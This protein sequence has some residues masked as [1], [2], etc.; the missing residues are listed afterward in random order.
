M[1]VK[2]VIVA[3]GYGSR[4]LPVTRCVPKEM[5][6]ILDRP[7]IDYVLQEFIEAG[8]E[9][10]LV[11]SSRRKGALEDWFDRDPELEAVF[12]AEGRD[13]KLALIAPPKIRATVIRQTEMKGTG[14]ALML[15][16]NFAGTDPIVVAYPDD[17]FGSPNVSA[18]LVEMWKATGCSVMCAA[19]L[20]ERVLSRYGVLEV[21]EGRDRL[22]H[23]RTIVEKPAH[24]TA[25]SNLVSFGRFLFTPELFRHLEEGWATH[26]GGEYYHVHA[27][28]RLGAAGKL[29]A[30]ITTA[31]RYDT[32]TTQAWLETQ[33]DLALDDPGLG[34]AL[35]A[36]L[37]DRLG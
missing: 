8:I 18:Q 12:G 21:E 25:P 33:I 36:F 35:R 20:E 34:P 30:A 17:L 24:G 15:A 9:E 31:K 26:S 4:M 19:R 22:L 10:V 37:K 23:I 7:A 11:I 6:P 32:G 27:L 28:N 14:H 3:A 1:A 13:D 2:G 29:V 16:R 5:L